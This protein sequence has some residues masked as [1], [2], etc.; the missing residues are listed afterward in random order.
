MSPDLRILIIADD[1]LAR[2]GLA[3]LLAEQ[4]GC[5]VAGRATR[6][7]DL[8]AA[9]EV[10]RPDVLLW[11]LGWDPAPALAR[12]AGYISAARTD[13]PIAVLLSDGSHAARVWSAGARVLLPRNADPEHLVA[14]L[15]AAA[16]GLA[17]IAP[18]FA[19]ILIHAP[20]DTETPRARPE[21][22]DLV[23]N[24]TPRELE[25]LRLLAEGLPNKAIALRLGRSEHTVKFHVNAIL[26]KLAVASRTEAV[27]RATRLGLIP[28]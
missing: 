13:E 14:A 4:P 8:G 3:A 23:E 2:A 26:G 17:V 24:L 9:V 12:L 16:H 20:A 27:V 10:G 7:D 11:D 25:V 1:P 22:A 5:V 6:A 28:L 15:T 21:Q 19:D 18:E